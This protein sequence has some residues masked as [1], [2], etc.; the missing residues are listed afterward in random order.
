MLW[1]IIKHY[2]K[3]KIETKNKYKL[4]P[5]NIINRELASR[6]FKELLKLIN[7]VKYLNKQPAEME[8]IVLK[9][10][11]KRLFFLFRATPMAYGGSQAGV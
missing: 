11:Q 10:I 4:F 1:F 3:I 5:I 6:L 2:L 8:D 9:K 7:T